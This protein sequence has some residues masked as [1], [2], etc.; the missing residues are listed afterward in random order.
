MFLGYPIVDI[1][2]K[3]RAYELNEKWHD[4]RRIAQPAGYLVARDDVVELFVELVAL[5]GVRR[6][7]VLT[8]VKAA[9]VIS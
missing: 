4:G 9:G 7:K 6:S 8:V 3:F 2:H 5:V 1:S